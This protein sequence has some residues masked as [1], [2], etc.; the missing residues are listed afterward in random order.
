[1]YLGVR[2]DGMFGPET[3]SIEEFSKWDH[4]NAR[5]MVMEVEPG[6]KH[7]QLLDISLPAERI[8]VHGNANR[9]DRPCPLRVKH[10]DD[11]HME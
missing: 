10:R 3:V 7:V 2:V 1:V 4:R 9:G 5:P 6:L 11:G 8:G